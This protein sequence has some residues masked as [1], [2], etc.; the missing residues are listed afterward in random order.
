MIYILHQQDTVKQTT[1]QHLLFRINLLINPVRG[2]NKRTL[3]QPKVDE[4]ISWFVE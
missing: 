4:S 3:G 1:S 2:A